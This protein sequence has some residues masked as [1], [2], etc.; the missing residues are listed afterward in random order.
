MAGSMSYLPERRDAYQ[1]PRS[2]LDRA[3]SVLMLGAS[4]YRGGG[5]EEPLPPGQA[6]I[7]KYAWGR[8]DYHDWIHPRL[9]G[10]IQAVQWHWPDLSARGVVDTAP[11][12]ERD[13]AR[14]AG[15]GWTGKNT[16]LIN[17]RF[18]S[19][20]FLAA[21]VL[22]ATLEYDPIHESDHC[23]TCTRCLDACP[24]GAFPEPGVLD[25]RQCISYLTIEHRGPVDER[26]R[27]GIGE[28][29]FG[30]DVCQDVCPWNRH[31]SVAPLA[32]PPVELVEPTIA[33]EEILRLDEI[34][35]RARFRGTPMWRSKREG[36][37]RNAAYV[38]GNR[39]DS[40]NTDDLCRL[41][42]LDPS[43]T[44]RGACAWALG[45]IN[46]EAAQAVLLQQQFCETDV[47]VQ[48]EIRAAL[49]RRPNVS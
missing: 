37:V 14:L 41:L 4:Y 48:N 22:D 6:R 3:Q 5:T 27:A 9:K 29:W 28:W 49:S 8:E 36:A 10:L 7:A 31:A 21:I 17:K 20:F 33:V 40:R 19:Y 46:T 15:L 35:F 25:A 26:L 30:C 38:A 32:A 23:G 24:T 45:Q 43:P 12:L 16:M 18:G 42:T 39:R 34:G 13:F 1:H 44:I 11:L 47:Q 2:I